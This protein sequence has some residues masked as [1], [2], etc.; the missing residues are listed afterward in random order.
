VLEAKPRGPPVHVAL[1]FHRRE[2]RLGAA[3]AGA[4]EERP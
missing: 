1:R 4:M 2:H 3:V